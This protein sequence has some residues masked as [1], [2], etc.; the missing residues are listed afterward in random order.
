MRLKRGMLVVLMLAVLSGAAARAQEE[1]PEL[2]T[3]AW[4]IGTYWSYETLSWTADGANRRGPVTYVVLGHNIWLG[5]VRFAMGVIW[6]WYDRSARLAVLEISNPLWEYMRWPPIAEFLSGTETT[7]SKTGLTFAAMR[8]PLALGSKPVRIER[9][10]G[11][12]VEP[13][14]GSSAVDWLAA[15]QQPDWLSDE[16]GATP[17][18]E[19]VTLIPGEATELTV[20]AG[21]FVD[22]LP[23]DYT[24]TGFFR[25]VTGRAWLSPELLWWVGAEGREETAE[26]SL[27]L[28]YTVTLTGWGVFAGQELAATL[29]AALESME[30]AERFS[31]EGLRL[32][33]SELGF[34]LP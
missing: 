18:V 13:V 2:Q 15:W 14:T 22:A 11:S 9:V 17:L 8:T 33:L 20:P 32:L 28:G 34:D 24:W 30:A 4:D 29:A 3:T 23:V 19:T 12:N 6:E 7:S 27:A 10:I 25:R 26:G 21:T 31:T 1:V 5:D 16:P